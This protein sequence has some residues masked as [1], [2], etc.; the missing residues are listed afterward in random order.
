MAGK[1]G[2][3]R[4]GLPTKAFRRKRTHSWRN[5]VVKCYGAAPQPT[6]RAKTPGS[7][8]TVPPPE[9]AKES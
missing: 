5:D 9:K 8:K 3:K 6:F 7:K 1:N 4:K 2:R